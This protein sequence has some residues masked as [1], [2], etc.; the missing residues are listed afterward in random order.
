[1]KIIVTGGEALRATCSRCSKMLW[2]PDD[3][4]AWLCSECALR[5]LE[6][7]K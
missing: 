3:G 4:S 1:M 5:E 7:A 6:E 2:V